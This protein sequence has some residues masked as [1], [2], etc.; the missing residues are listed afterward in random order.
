MTY[1]GRWTYKYEEAARRGAAGVLVVH[2][3]EPASYGWATVK[4][5]QHQHHVRHRPRR[6]R[7][8]EHPPLEGW[9]QRDLAAQLF[10]A[11]G[12]DFEAMKAAAKTQGLQAGR[13]SRP[14][15]DA[16]RRRQDRGHHL[17]QRR[18]PAARHDASRRDRDLH[19]ATGTISASASPTP[20]ATASTMA[21]STTRTGIAQLIEQ[22]RAFASGPRP[23]RSVVF[24][25]VDRRGK[26]PARQRILC[27]QPALS[28]R[29]DGRR[30]STPTCWACSARRAISR[31]SRQRRSSDCSTCWSPKAPSAAAATRP[32]RAPEAGSFFRSDHFTFAKV[33]VPAISF[34]VGQGS[35]QRRR[36]ARRGLARGLHRQAL[37]PAGR[38]IFAGLG[39][40]RHGR[41]TPSCSTPSACGS[42][43][44]TTG[45]TGAQDSEFR[46]DARRDRRRAR[47]RDLG[48]AG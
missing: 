5:S 37:P 35:G 28:A 13:R 19:R 31:I 22:A 29:Q 34:D 14:T 42:P 1:Y 12:L 3:T 44:A 48:S 21:R 25:A 39:L 38:R 2:E 27:R 46:A 43:T 11:S 45:R 6:T 8:A 33:G 36:R 26:G 7:R 18:R 15:L 24:L 9:I 20:T 32:I 40:H 16:P 17:A 10:A 47:R 41:R 23:E 4:N 30:A